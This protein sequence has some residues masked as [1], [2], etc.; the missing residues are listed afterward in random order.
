VTLVKK[1][2]PRE[3]VTIV[4]RNSRKVDVTL[5]VVGKLLLKSS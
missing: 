2:Y 4:K 5:A 3:S 1:N